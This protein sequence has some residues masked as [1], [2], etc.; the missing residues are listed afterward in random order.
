MSKQ[1]VAKSIKLSLEL[2]RYLATHPGAYDKIP[3]GACIVITKEGDSAFNKVSHKIAE[4]SA[5][6]CVEAR[7]IGRR[8]SI[9]PRK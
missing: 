2:D 3:R 7:K 9:K 4:G 1:Y 5:E 6:K 8:W